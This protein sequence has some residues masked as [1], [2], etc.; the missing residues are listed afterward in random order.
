MSSVLGG[1]GAMPALRFNIGK[2]IHN[3]QHK[4]KHPSKQTKNLSMKWIQA[5][6]DSVLQFL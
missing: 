4:T 5:V 6:C 1:A 3:T 2:H